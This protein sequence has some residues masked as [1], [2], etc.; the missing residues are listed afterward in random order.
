M[1]TPKSTCSIYIISIVP[2]VLVKETYTITERHTNRIKRER[3]R[4]WIGHVLRMD[5]S[6]TTRVALHWTPDGKIRRGRPRETWIRT[7]ECDLKQMGLTWRKAERKAKDR[8]KW[9]KLV[10]AV[11]TTHYEERD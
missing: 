8:V 2:L 1:R 10:M 5:Q 6:N 7:V 4:K 3:G 9:R 11:C